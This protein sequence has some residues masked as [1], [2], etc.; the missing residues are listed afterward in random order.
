MK[1]VYEDF[2]ALDRQKNKANSKPISMA[3]TGA[4]WI[5][6]FAGMTNMGN[7]KYGIPARLKILTQFEKTKPI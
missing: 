3:G 5:P 4:D 7:D 6:A 1:G 2:H